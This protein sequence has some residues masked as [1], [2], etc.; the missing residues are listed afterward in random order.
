MKFFADIQKKWKKDDEKSGK[1]RSFSIESLYGSKTSRDEIL[2]K[3]REV[4]EKAGPDDVVF[5]Y[6]LCH[7]GHVKGSLEHTHFFTPTALS[8]DSWTKD[9]IIYRREIQEILNE[10]EH[11]LN[12][13]I[14]DTCAHVTS[15]KSVGSSK[16]GILTTVPEFPAYDS[17]FNDFVGTI[18][19]N[20]TSWKGGMGKK[21][22]MAIGSS[23]YGTAFTR[24]LIST[25]QQETQ[26]SRYTKPK[27][28]D[29][30]QME[31]NQSFNEL[32]R[33]FKKTMMD[34]STRF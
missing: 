14:T 24:A 28:L 30:L 20:S 9:D 11:R 22:E 15:K 10:N 23:D 33:S 32:K 4:S 19:I 1:I 25:L 26:P 6:V 21:G 17:I 3:C 34:Y 5:I 8:A 12:I 27:F 7:G 29:A 2:K 13:L 18:N 31:T 16:R